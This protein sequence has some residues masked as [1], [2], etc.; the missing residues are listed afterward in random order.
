MVPA[1]YGTEAKSLTLLQMAI[2]QPFFYLIHLRPELM[3]L[4]SL[5]LMLYVYGTQV[6]IVS[7]DILTITDAS[8]SAGTA[9]V[10]KLHNLS[11]YFWKSI[12]INMFPLIIT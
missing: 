2:N 6:I 11:K 5:V 4:T 7:A 3:T 12:I 10:T 8:P 9:M 1:Y